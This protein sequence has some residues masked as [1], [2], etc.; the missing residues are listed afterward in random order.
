MTGPLAHIVIPFDIPLIV[1]S[2]ALG[3]SIPVSVAGREGTMHWPGWTHD[4]GTTRSASPPVGFEGLDQEWGSHTSSTADLTQVA[5][6]S[7]GFSFQ[8]NPDEV[9]IPAEE[10]NQGYAKGLSALVEPLRSWMGRFSTVATHVLRQ[11]LDA[12]EPPLENISPRSQQLLHWLSMDGERSW[13]SSE[14]GVIKVRVQ[15][16]PRPWSELVGDRDSIDRIVSLTSS[17]EMIPSP[18]VLMGAARLAAHR[19]RARLALM[20]LGTCLEAILTPLVNL[21]PDHKETLGPLTKL[22]LA[23]GVNL[24]ADIKT[25]FVVPRNNAVHNGVEPT[26]EVLEGA[27][28]IVSPL[29]NADYPQWAP[30]PKAP[31]AHRPQRL[32]LAIVPPPS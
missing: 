10:L 9:A 2:S 11:S 4:H 8:L 31:I 1:L 7:V 21:P 13:L 12:T 19:G 30:S 23:M 14:P 5:V 22:A 18:V 16:Q 24:P 15:T 26:Y 17:E 27:F 25:A 6:D 29:V 3:R 32:D 28:N 20:E